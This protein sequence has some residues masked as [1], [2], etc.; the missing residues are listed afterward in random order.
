MLASKLRE[1][2][3]SL[4]EITRLI[5]VYPEAWRRW[6]WGPERGGCACLGCARQPAPSTVRGDPE[7]APWP[8]ENDALSEEEV[9]I[10]QASL[11]KSC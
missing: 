5:L 1:T 3:R 7:Y 2:P 11:Q 9:Q 6:C 8:D 4:E 10:Y